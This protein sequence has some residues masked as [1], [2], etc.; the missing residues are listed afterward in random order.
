M[1]VIKKKTRKKLRKF[2]KKHG[3]AVV[4]GLLGSVISAVAAR[5]ADDDG[6]R[7][8]LARQLGGKKKRKKTED[9]IFA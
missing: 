6:L 1:A 4:T 8:T 2:M 9:G 3:D 7:A 5:Y